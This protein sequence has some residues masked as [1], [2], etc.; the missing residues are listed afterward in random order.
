MEIIQTYNKN[1]LVK[2]FK[3]EQKGMLLSSNTGKYK[4]VGEVVATSVYI[5]KNTK[6]KKKDIIFF[7]TD[8]GIKVRFNDEFFILLSVN[9]ILGSTTDEKN[10][11]V[12][13]SNGHEQMFQYY[14]KVANKNLSKGLVEQ[15]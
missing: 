12:I 1:L 5:D 3:R 8:R 15:V 2:P 7:D 9:Q 10:L 6:F 13:E 4:D 14:Q 11:E